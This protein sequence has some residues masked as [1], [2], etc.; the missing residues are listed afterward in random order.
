MGFEE[1]QQQQKAI[2]DAEKKKK[3]EAVKSLHK[4][5]FGGEL[6]DDQ[7]QQAKFKREFKDRKKSAVSNLH[8]FKGNRDAM[9]LVSPPKSPTRG[10]A[11]RSVEEA[12]EGD[13]AAEAAVADVVAA[14]AGSAGV[15]P[16]T[17]VDVK[18]KVSSLD[19]K[20]EEEDYELL[21]AGTRPKFGPGDGGEEG[22]PEELAS[23]VAAASSGGGVEEL[24]DDVAA[25]SLGEQE[26]EEERD[27]NEPTLEEM[28]AMPESSKQMMKDP[29]LTRIKVDFKFGMVLDSSEAEPSKDM[30]AQ[31]A[32]DIVPSKFMHEMIEEKDIVYNPE[33][34]PVVH[35]VQKDEDFVPPENLQDQDVT[36]WV[37]KGKVPVFLK[38]KAVA[39]VSARRATLRASQG[40]SFRRST[41]LKAPEPK[42]EGEEVVV[43][44]SIKFKQIREGKDTA[45][46]H[47]L[48]ESLLS[49]EIDDEPDDAP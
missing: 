32:A 30:C 3:Q 14:A 38:E 27:A 19:A 11:E 29:N 37:V 26:E 17:G 18:G 22:S 25:A 31:A 16:M 41:P 33:D 46:E 1:W 34:P 39:D 40:H 20:K 43:G 8:G 2:Q 47:V 13:V 44:K 15:D 42:K 5:Q 21:G 49:K 7:K 12:E 10:G 23:E 35:T 48:E 28:M 24:A 4:P 6:R 45:W 36:R 9:G